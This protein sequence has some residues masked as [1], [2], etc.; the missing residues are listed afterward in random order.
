MQIKGTEANL[1]YPG[2]LNEQIYSFANLIEDADTAPN[3]QETSNLRRAAREARR[4]TRPLDEA[5]AEP[6]G[7]VPRQAAERRWEVII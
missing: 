6:A 3:M 2:M 7:S 1:N 4:R 5:P